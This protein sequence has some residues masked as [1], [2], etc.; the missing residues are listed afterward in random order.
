MMMEWDEGFL[1]HSD[2][3]EEAPNEIVNVVIIAASSPV[4]DKWSIYGILMISLP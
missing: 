4:K 1:T 2:A 3:R